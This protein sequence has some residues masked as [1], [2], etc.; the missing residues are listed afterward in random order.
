MAVIPTS[1]QADY[2]DALGHRVYLGGTGATISLPANQNAVEV[3]AFFCR[4]H[5]PKGWPRVLFLAHKTSILLHAFE[6]FSDILG[7]SLSYGVFGV[8]KEAAKADVMFSTF[9][10]MRGHLEE[11]S[12]DTFDIVICEAAHHAIADTF[13]DAVAHFKKAKFRLAMSDLVSDFFERDNLGDVLQLFGPLI[14]YMTFEEAYA[15]RLIPRMIYS[16][17][18]EH[19]MREDGLDARIGGAGLLTFVEMNRYIVQPIQDEKLVAIIRE[20]VENTQNAKV[21]IFCEN[22]WRAKRIAEIFQTTAF[23]AQTE[24]YSQRLAEFR[25]SKSGII[26]AVWSLN[27]GAYLDD[28]NLIF[29]LGSIRG[30]STILHQLASG[31]STEPDKVLRIYDFVDSYAR[32]LLLE[33]MADDFR[34]S[35]SEIGRFD[36]EDVFIFDPHARYL[37]ELGSNMVTLGL[38]DEMLEE[39][40]KA[41]LYSFVAVLGRHL[42]RKEHIRLSQKKR[43]HT[44][45]A[46]R[47]IFGSMDSAYRAIDHDRRLSETLSDSELLLPLSDLIE[48]TITDRKRLPTG[49]EID[50]AFHRNELPRGLSAYL[51]RFG[52]FAQAYRLLGYDVKIRTH[53]SYQD[54][55]DGFRRVA[56]LLGYLPTY[57]HLVKFSRRGVCPNQH[58]YMRYFPGGIEAIVA[59][60]GYGSVKE[61]LLK[62]IVELHRNVAYQLSHLD[63]Q[64]L[65]KEG[66]CNALLRYIKQYHSWGK[67]IEAADECMNGLLLSRPKTSPEVLKLLDGFR[68]VR[69]SLG[70]LPSV[71]EIDEYSTR[72]ECRDYRI[73]LAIFP[74]GIEEIVSAAGY[75]TIQ[76]VLLREFLTVQEGIDHPLSFDEVV[77]I[78]ITGRC[79]HPNR[80]IRYFGDWD[81]FLQAAG[82]DPNLVVKGESRR[83]PI[84]RLIDD[85]KRLVEH[86]KRIPTYE[87]MEYACT[88]G[89]CAAPTVYMRYFSGIE[90]IVVSAGLG[91]MR[92]ALL[93]EYLKVQGEDGRA[94]SVGEWDAIAGVRGLN[95]SRR[96][97]KYF[98]GWSNLMEAARS[99]AEA[100]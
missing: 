72:G 29:F 30:R 9:K 84:K 31:T 18:A 20:K 67:V 88:E 65:H 62:E 54:C 2:L 50:E 11:F 75:G 78:S 39:V 48:V 57:P 77:G 97:S 4:A 100:Q 34:Q 52:S 59:A 70:Y 73:F 40:L 85:F 5:Q 8:D 22:V 24:N 36:Q 37:L 17:V 56:E 92:E 10:M 53:E 58:V 99:S 61:A 64:A 27:E 35:A 19:T 12:S 21:V 60:A 81:K 47:R 7:E 74:G 66:K 71:D 16:V 89:M 94:L 86:K 79:N 15:Q 6:T 96:F 90:E 1:I 41:E 87:E 98:G 55:L 43:I 69:K 44:L 14:R 32:L 3:A 13:R 23:C 76:E 63:V 95:T 28:V 49:P 91:T 51:K 82:L 45:G 46:Y 25:R 80:F 38:P 93:R 42:T 26:T 68:R 33:A 83:Y